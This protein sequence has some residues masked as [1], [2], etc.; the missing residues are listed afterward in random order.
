MKP[1]DVKQ[2][3][4]DLKAAIIAGAPVEIGEKSGA[5][6]S[7]LTLAKLGQLESSMQNLLSSDQ[8]SGSETDKTNKKSSLSQ[9]TAL[10][11]DF[12]K[13]YRAALL[14]FAQTH[15]MVPVLDG[16][17]VRSIAQAQVSQVMRRAFI[18]LVVLL[19]V[20]YCGLSFFRSNLIP[21]IDD[22]RAEIA[23]AAGNVTPERFEST[24]WLPVIVVLVGCG[25]LLL[26][27]GMLVG[28][29]FRVSMCLGGSHYVRCRTSN[30]AIRT[31]QLLLGTGLPVDEAVSIS[32]DLTGADAKVRRDIQAVAKDPPNTLHLK[33]LARYLM[34]SANQRLAY[35]TVAAP[36]ALICSV[37]GGVALIYCLVLFWPVVTLLRELSG[38][39][40]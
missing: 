38:V 21:Q 4:D 10:Q 24:L 14:T 36:T 28:G 8:S 20:A 19:A 33:S 30:S 7:K 37:G 11:R 16:L 26:V 5:R 3:H 32:C 29:A 27:L 40:I 17:S 22:L 1:T 15:S 34:I 6:S 23:L 25:L 12:P 31:L 9:L 18:Y 13:R 39:G 35:L 2:F